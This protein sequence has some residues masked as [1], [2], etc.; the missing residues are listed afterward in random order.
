MY[1]MQT[2]T[3]RRVREVKI[4]HVQAN[5]EI[6]YAYCGNTAIDLHPLPVSRARLTGVERALFK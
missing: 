6:F 3:T 1:S 2:V 5:R 4:H